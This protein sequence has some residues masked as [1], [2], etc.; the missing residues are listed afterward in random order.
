[1]YIEK[2]VEKLTLKLRY[3]DIVHVVLYYS[4]A[5]INIDMSEC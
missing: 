3:Q 4:S 5:A 1:M 2:C